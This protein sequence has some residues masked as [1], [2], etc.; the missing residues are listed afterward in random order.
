MDD[1]DLALLLL[2]IRDSRTPYAAL[3]KRLKMSIP[4]V[5]KRIAAL[6]DAGAIKKFIA[7]LSW[8]YL[9]A[10]P[11]MV[12]GPSGIFPLRKAVERLGKHDAT[13]IVIQ[14]SENT[15][16]IQAH[17]QD[18]QALGPYVA[19]CRKVAAMPNPVVG[20]ESDVR[21]G[22]GPPYATPE[23][24]ELDPIDYRILWSLHD[25]ARKPIADICKEL[26]VSPKTVRV[27]LRRMRDGGIA[28]FYTQ[29]Q[30]GQLAGVL[31]FFILSLRPDVE[32]SAFRG[33]LI[34]ELGL[35]VIWSTPLSNAPTS[36]PM[37]IWS[38][39]AVAHEGLVERLSA[40]E[41]M[42]KVVG[43]IST[44]FDFFETWRDELLQERATE[45]GRS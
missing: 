13:R 1:T 40:D 32:P 41:A 25:D 33:R 20:I 29:L 38:P 23:V 2:L 3:A 31:A 30:I 45:S 37:L 8:P 39:T 44:Q 28:E 18:V 42:E 6:Q 11:V 4:S 17:L 5:H 19:Y 12:W 35:R 16:Y 9:S 34:S 21:Y 27:R 22:S 26:R 24:T 7:N 10:V 15:L 36:L 43:Y 14:G